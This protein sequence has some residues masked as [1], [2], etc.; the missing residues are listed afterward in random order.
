MAPLVYINAS[1]FIET[2]KQ[3]GL[4]I[5]SAKEFQANNEIERNRLMRRKSLALSEIVNANLLPLKTVKGVNDWIISG[6]IKEGE[7]YQETSGYKRVM[8]LTQAIK[9]LGYGE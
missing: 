8:V 6:K 3:Q 7:W 4:V 9:R 5:V 2:L 1:E